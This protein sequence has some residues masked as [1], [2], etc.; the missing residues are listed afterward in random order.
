MSSLPKFAAKQINEVATLL[1]ARQLMQK[2]PTSVATRL[3]EQSGVKVEVE[4][5]SS[6]EQAAFL[7]QMLKHINGHAISEPSQNDHDG[8]STGAQADQVTGTADAWYPG[9]HAKEAMQKIGILKTK[10]T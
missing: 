5:K 9:K 2:M 6:Q 7:F 1:M 10:S 3:K 4:G 8:P